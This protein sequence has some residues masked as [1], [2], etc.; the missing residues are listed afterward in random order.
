MGDQTAM[1]LQLSCFQGK[2]CIFIFDVDGTLIENGSISSE[3]LPSL[4]DLKK[5]NNSLGLCSSQSPVEVSKFLVDLLGPDLDPNSVFDAGFILEDGHVWVPPSGHLESDAEVLTSSEALAEMDIFKAAFCALWKPASEP[6]LRDQHWGFINGG[7][8]LP[9][10][11]AP[12]E[13]QVLGSVSIWEKGPEITSPAYRGEYDAMMTWARALVKKLGLQYVE[14][15]EVGN[16]TLRVLE[17]G[18]NKGTTLARVCS[19]LVRVVY[20]GNGLNDVPAA[21]VVREAQGLV[22]VVANA[23][24]ELKELAHY[25]ASW[26]ASSGVVELLKLL[27]GREI[28]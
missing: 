20:I 27:I 11:L 3:L 13:F 14:L 6:K 22:M 25:R 23:P 4:L 18:V 19:S 15:G 10:Q 7:P 21:K 2:N 24:T 17:L 9:V 28:E 16:G 26:P 8:D 5:R 12:K 1:S